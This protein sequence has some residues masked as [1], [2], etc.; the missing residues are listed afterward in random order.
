MPWKQ[1]RLID[2]KFKET[3]K[4]SVLHLDSGDKGVFIFKVYYLVIN[5]E[6]RPILKDLLESGNTTEYVWADQYLIN[7]LRH[8]ESEKGYILEI[9][10]HTNWALNMQWSKE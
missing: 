3:I 5:D 4:T 7:R 6:Q 9:A 2:Y 1:F 10:Q 8:S